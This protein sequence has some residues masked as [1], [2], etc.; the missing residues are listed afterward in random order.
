MLAST[1]LVCPVCATAHPPGAQRCSH[2]SSPLGDVPGPHAPVTVTSVVLGTRDRPSLLRGCTWAAPW[3]VF[4]HN[5]WYALSVP[6]GC[7]L[8][9]PDGAG[10]IDDTGRAGET[11]HGAPGVWEPFGRPPAI[12][13]TTDQHE[14]SAYALRERLGAPVWAPE[15]GLAAGGDL[16]GRP[17][18]TYRGGSDLPG[19]LRAIVPG[20]IGGTT[21]A[22]WHVLAWRAPSGERVLFT[23]DALNGPAD[24][25]HPLH[26]TLDRPAPGLYAGA[27]RDHL[28]SAGP[29]ALH[30]ALMP[31]LA[32]RADLICG[33]H[34]VPV[35]GAHALLQRILAL[36]WQAELNAGNDVCVLAPS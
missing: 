28:V 7:V 29:R 3:W 31:L 19:G 20:G 25:R 16:E 35:T 34:G 4:G 21:A 30:D 10:D 6:G 2:C 13:L 1:V 23:G 14:R 15:A 5:D 9:D 12:V 17:D 33:G 26:A 27:S 24:P 8:V 11:G 18:R 36:D 32:A 22:A